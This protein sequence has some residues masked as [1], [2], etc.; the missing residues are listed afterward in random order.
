MRKGNRGKTYS[1][2]EMQN[3]KWVRMTPNAY[4]LA[5]ARNVWQ[6]ALLAAAFGGGNQRSLRPAARVEI[7]GPTQAAH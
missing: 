7:C 6:S 1:L 3:G 5:T 4:H 2:F